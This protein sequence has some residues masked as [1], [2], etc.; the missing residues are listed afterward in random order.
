M[1]SSTTAPRRALIVIDV[2]NEYFAGGNLPIE[3]PP[4]ADTLPNIIRA[5]DVAQAAGVPVVVV[6]HTAPSGAPVFDKATERWQLHPEVARRPADHHI[7][8]NFASVFTNTGLAEWLTE[9]GID[10]LTV[11]GY[12]THNCDASTIYEASHR[13]LGVEF[14]SDASG[15]LPYANAAGSAS[16]EEIHR[17]FSVVF[18]SNFAAA[19]STRDWVAAVQAGQALPKDNVFASNQRARKG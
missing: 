16:A 6:Q 19:A 3:Y 5:M 9:R 13:G 4:V 12:M 1:T 15:A 17:V 8:K 7:E 14:L 18:H 11:V 2:Q 10:T